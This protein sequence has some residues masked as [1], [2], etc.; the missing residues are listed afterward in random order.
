MKQ[1]KEMKPGIKYRGYGYVN[2]FGEF[3]F[4]PEETGSRA[5]VISPV[6]SGN[7]YTVTMTK[8]Y[9]L[10]HIKI[11]RSLEIVSKIKNLLSITNSLISVF[12]SYDF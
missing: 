6:T 12:K 2:N 1:E 10:C 8:K 4:E 9:V 7:G 11:D 3:I 5:G